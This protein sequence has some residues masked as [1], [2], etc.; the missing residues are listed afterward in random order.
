MYLNVYIYPTLPQE[1]DT[2]QSIFKLSLIGLSSFSYFQ[3][4]LPYSG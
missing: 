4:Q 3:D 2:T 1:Q